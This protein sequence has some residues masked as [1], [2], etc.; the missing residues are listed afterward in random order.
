MHRNG[1]EALLRKYKAIQ[2]LRGEPGGSEPE[3]AKAKMR[4]LAEE[5]P[6]SLRELDKLEAEAIASRVDEI[7]RALR[8]DVSAPW[9][10]QM[11]AF[12]LELRSAL[13]LKRILGKQAQARPADLESA[14]RQVSDDL[15]VDCTIAL[16]EDVVARDD[17]RLSQMIIERVAR[18]AGVTA[19][20]VED[21]LFPEKN[22]GSRRVARRGR[23]SWS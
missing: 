6:G 4:A 2:S 7:E 15:G 5:F 8:S 3:V 21:N 9:M 12:H 18:A 20:E 10:D 22:P 11:V 13:S 16:A 19:V 14:C 1:L 23:R 17:G